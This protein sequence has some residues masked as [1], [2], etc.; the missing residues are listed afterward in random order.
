MSALSLSK[1]GRS[2]VVF[3]GAL[4]LASVQAR[5]HVIL[6]AP[7]GGEVLEAGSVFT[8][9]WHIHIVHN[10]LNWDLWYS[11]TG[12]AGPWVSIAQDL[13][14]GSTAEGSVHTYDWTV[15][16]D[17]SSQVRI[18]VRM[19]NSGTDYEDISNGDL[20]IETD[21]PIP[22]VSEWGMIVMALLMLTAG[23]IA[24]FRGKLILMEE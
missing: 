7:N 12:A 15:P 13:P 2:A 23:T 20:T 3:V 16:D 6:D 5:G 17:P 18:R 11:T 9:E 1:V 21:V 4:C 19:D 10:Q 8:I 14:P 22:T 24:L